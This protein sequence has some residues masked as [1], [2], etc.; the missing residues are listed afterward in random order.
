MQI[1]IAAIDPPPRLLLF[2][3]NT[4]NEL[5]LIFACSRCIYDILQGKLRPGDIALQIFPSDPR[6]AGI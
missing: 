4:K 1:F 2:D 5:Y 3:G 6:S